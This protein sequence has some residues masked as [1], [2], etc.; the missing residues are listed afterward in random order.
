[1]LVICL[2]F[3]FLNEGFLLLKK[4]SCHIS[5]RPRNNDRA[6]VAPLPDRLKYT[7]LSSR[8]NDDINLFMYPILPV[9][10]R[11]NSVG[12]SK[13]KTRGV[14]I[15]VCHS[16]YLHPV[17][18]TEQFQQCRAA[19]ASSDNQYSFHFTTP[20]NILRNFIVYQSAYFSKHGIVPTSLPI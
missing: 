15:D 12:F 13:S 11:W 20:C 6:S 9:P 18:L 5:H 4:F 17:H 2:S 3:Q 16:H 1:M 10:A 7:F 14:R 19:F 8:F